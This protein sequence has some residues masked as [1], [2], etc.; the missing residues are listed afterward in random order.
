[1]QVRIKGRSGPVSL[2]SRSGPGQEA[3]PR[4]RAPVLELSLWPWPPETC[5][6]GWM[7][8]P[9]LPSTPLSPDDAP[10]V[11]QAKKGGKSQKN[12]NYM[13]QT[14]KAISVYEGEPK[15]TR[16]KKCPL[17]FRH[18]ILSNRRM[19]TRRGHRFKRLLQAMSRAGCVPIKLLMV[20]QAQRVLLKLSR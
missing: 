8:L 14:P 10:S 5:S 7:F 4:V 17:L 9:A 15:R 18:V 11:R 3:G 12:S 16:S 6:P 19:V 13:L 1:M 20:Q 2:V